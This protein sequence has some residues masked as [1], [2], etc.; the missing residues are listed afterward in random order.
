[1][2]AVEIEVLILIDGEESRFLAH[3]I[4]R[5]ESLSSLATGRKSALLFLGVCIGKHEIRGS[6]SASWLTCVIEA[7]PS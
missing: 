7:L 2:Q 5:I 1:M 6:Y 4:F 3:E